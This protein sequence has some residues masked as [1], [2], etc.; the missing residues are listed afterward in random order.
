MTDLAGTRDVRG[1]EKIRERFDR[2]L[3][4]DFET[5]PK[6]GVFH[7]GAVFEDRVFERKNIRDVKTALRELTDFAQGAEY[8]L[9]HN[10]FNH[11]LARAREILP[12]AGFLDLPVIDTLFLSPLAFPE[13]PYHKLVKGY[14]LVKSSKNN[15]LSDARLAWD[16][17]CD[18]L[19]AF[20]E[21]SVK[22]PGL[23]DVFHFAFESSKIS[24][25]KD[26]FRLFTGTAPDEA[27]A[28]E[29]FKEICRDK[30]C[31]NGLD[32]VFD[33]CCNRPPSRPQLAYLLSW[34]R[35]SGGNSILPPWVKHEFPEIGGMIRTLRFSCGDNACGFCKKHH[36]SE[37]LL[38]QFFGFDRYRALTDG[39]VLQKE[40]KIGRAHV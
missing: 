25:I 13:N 31:P 32:R 5:V 27:A 26:V 3:V 35:V 24:G 4:I 18:Q 9:G 17:F 10:I 38:K 30:A 19:S 23:L 20:S 21:L 33:S 22:E 11:D 28:K 8:I 36:D 39:R 12:E 16:V 15:P 2:V 6:G 37:T 40:I 1:F 34:L 29:R 14:K 7:V